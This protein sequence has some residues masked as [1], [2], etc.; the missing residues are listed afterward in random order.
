M[1]MVTSRYPLIRLLGPQAIYS[2]RTLRKAVR[3]PREPRKKVEKLPTIANTTANGEKSID[4]GP[5]ATCHRGV[6]TKNDLSPQ[7]T[8]SKGMVFVEENHSNENQNINTPLVE[9][10]VEALAVST[11]VGCGASPDDHPSDDDGGGGMI[12]THAQ[13][14]TFAEWLSQ[15]PYAATL[16]VDLE[17][18]D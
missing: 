17:K 11:V 8:Q 13:L 1:G 6:T 9:E 4:C 16:A 10:K 7:P 18:S 2:Q 15:L 12:R 14:S 5:Q 3:K